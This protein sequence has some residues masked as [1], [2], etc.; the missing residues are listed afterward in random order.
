[1]DISLI[2]DAPF[3]ARNSDTR[4]VTSPA[5]SPQYNIDYGSMQPL[6]IFQSSSEQTTSNFQ[7]DMINVSIQNV[8]VSNMTF[9]ET[10]PKAALFGSFN[11]DIRSLTLKN[12]IMH[13]IEQPLSV[14][15]L[16][17]LKPKSDILIQN[18]TVYN[19]NQN[20]FQKSTQAVS[21]VS[22]GSAVLSIIQ[23]VAQ[24]APILYEI[25]GLTVS[26]SYGSAGTAINVYTDYFFESP[27]PIMLNFKNLSIT[28]VTCVLGGAVFVYAAMDISITDSYFAFNKYILY[29]KDIHIAKSE[30]FTLENTTILGNTDQDMMV[31][32]IYLINDE[33]TQVNFNNITFKCN[34]DSTD[35][36]NKTYYHTKLE[37][38]V[39]LH[40]YATPIIIEQS[41]LSTTNS[42]FENCRNSM[43]G[44]VI[45]LENEAS[46]KDNG[47]VF[48]YNLGGS[49]G[50]IYS[51][52]S[53]VQLENTI[54]TTN[55]AQT[56]GAVHLASESTT[57]NWTNVTFHKNY[58]SM[59]AGAISVLSSSNL[60]ISSSIFTK[61]K[62]ELT[63]V[64]N[65]LSTTGNNIVAN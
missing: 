39:G 48:R 16:L 24:A 18:M 35:E 15:G 51:H 65:A 29:A 45:Y 36:H 3:Y 22:K 41:S 25:D 14:I 40:T 49:G 42:I 53:V 50:A 44:G 47:S 55:Y 1:M 19:I 58:A 30:S 46:Y 13:D 59:T 17:L 9:Y 11:E 12:T 62:A 4:V 57:V 64:I 26:N 33:Q 5:V 63:G 10:N 32:S 38:S 2:V 27:Q 21:Y 7:N 20:T 23:V 28:N 6:I 52:Y 54:F 61:N 8:V 56:S 34:P 37:N 31:N 60:V 43:I